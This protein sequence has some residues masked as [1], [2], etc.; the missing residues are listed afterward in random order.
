MSGWAT[1]L[2]GGIGL[3]K[4]V[5]G[6]QLKWDGEYIDPASRPLVV[7]T[8]F[9]E[10]RQRIYGHDVSPEWVKQGYDRLYLVTTLVGPASLPGPGGASCS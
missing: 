7:Y 6:A 9:K 4:S 2:G 5:E 8:D 1:K 3:P 10:R